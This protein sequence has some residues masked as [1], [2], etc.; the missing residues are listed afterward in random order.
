MTAQGLDEQQNPRADK[1]AIFKDNVIKEDGP[2][3]VMQK[4]RRRRRGKQPEYTYLGKKSPAVASGGAQAIINA[5]KSSEKNK[6][7]RFIA[8]EEEV[9][10]V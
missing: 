4:A 6:G 2:W 5:I 8:L 9:T 7:Y 1:G 10:I 3:L